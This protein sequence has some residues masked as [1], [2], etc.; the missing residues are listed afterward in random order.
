M[1]A[2]KWGR[3][4]ACDFPSDDRYPG[5]GSE[6]PAWGVKGTI[7]PMNRPTTL[8]LILCV[9][10]LSI[11][12]AAIMVR[13]CDDAPAAV[14]AAARLS[15]ASVILLV[16][17]ALKR[18][19]RL[20]QIRPGLMGHVLLGGLMLAAHFYFWMS[21]LWHTSVMS[22]VVIVTTNPIFVGLGSLFLFKE[23]IHWNLILGIALAGIGGLLIHLA[24]G[25]TAD[26]ARDSAY[27]NLLALL[28]ALTASGYL[29]VGRRV[30]RE[31]DNLSYMLAVYGIAGVILIGFCAAKGYSAWGYR[32]STYLWFAFLAVVPQL[33]GHGS[34]NFALQHLSATIV[35]V[36]ILA[37]P[38]GASI[39][40]II[41]L[42]EIPTGMQLG[43]SAVILL[44]IYLATRRPAGGPTKE[45]I[46]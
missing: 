13:L 9:G 34:L 27:G 5:A 43:G 3:L 31:V 1:P 40:A 20:V 41:F 24:G 32:P 30:R 18:G 26:A 11:S 28:G 42:K 38:V 36:C 37:E 10:M 12:S 2:D 7:L 4:L 35:S 33:L 39:L 46:D 16:G 8:P 44:G 45:I 14:T 29:L 21:S 19:Q 25:G 6:I 22:S 15:I 23:R 17:L